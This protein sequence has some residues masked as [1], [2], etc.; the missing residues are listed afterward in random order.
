MVK[1]GGLPKG[2]IGVYWIVNLI[3]RQVEVYTLRRH[4][5]YGNRACT[6]RANPCGSS[7]M[8]TEM[9]L[10]VVA[11]ILPRVAPSAKKQPSVIEDPIDR[12]GIPIA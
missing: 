7:S 12:N 1:S 3:D 11:E 10:I 4:N 9:G 6:S 5:G 8:A 2:G